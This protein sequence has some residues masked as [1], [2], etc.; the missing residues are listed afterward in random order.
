MGSLA[1][2]RPDMLPLLMPWLLSAAERAA[3]AESSAQAASLSHAVKTVLVQLLRSGALQ[4][5]AWQERAVAALAALG[6][7]VAADAALRQLERSTKRER[8][9]L[10]RCVGVPRCLAVRAHGRAHLAARVRAET[11]TPR[12][13][14]RT[15]RRRPRAARTSARTGSP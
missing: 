9:Q 4:T 12:T 11:K 6:Q 5:G 7:Q 10:E 8:A 14:T 13:T 2:Q 15:R 3:G 1:R